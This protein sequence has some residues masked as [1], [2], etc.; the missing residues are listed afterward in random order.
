M[1]K[2]SSI[3]GWNENENG[4]WECA[5]AVLIRLKLGVLS[6]PGPLLSSFSVEGLPKEGRA[7]AQWMFSNFQFFL[8]GR[9]F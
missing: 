1:I 3:V 5:L 4:Q 7:M 2:A 6:V 8:Y 9:G